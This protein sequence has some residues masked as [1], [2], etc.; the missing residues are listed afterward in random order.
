ME[1]YMWS[2]ISTVL[3]VYTRPSYFTQYFRWIAKI[4]PFGSNLHIVGIAALC[5]AIW[6]IRNNACFEGKLISS[7]VGLIC[8]MYAFLQYWRRTRS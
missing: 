2:T 5:W 4:L 3:G 8:Y 1:A 7:P 6:K